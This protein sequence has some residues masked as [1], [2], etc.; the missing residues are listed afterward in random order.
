MSN[1]LVGLRLGLGQ[2]AKDFRPIDFV[3]VRPRDDFERQLAQSRDVAVMVRPLKRRQ[4]LLVRK[5]RDLE[6]FESHQ[7]Q[8]HD[9]HAARVD[10]AER[11]QAQCAAQLVEVE[12]RHQLVVG[13]FQEQD[14][15]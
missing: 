5:L 10:R 3:E 12:V 11:R 1:R 14:C 8:L 9:V 6:P 13:S 2:D 15:G 7:R 4:E